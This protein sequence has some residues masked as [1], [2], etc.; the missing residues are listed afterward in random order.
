MQFGFHWFV[1]IGRRRI[2]EELYALGIL[3]RSVYVLTHAD[4]PNILVTL[5]VI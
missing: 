4:H 1:N 2:D 3:E 5:W